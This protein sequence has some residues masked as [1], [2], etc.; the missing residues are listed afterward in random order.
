MA[1]PRQAVLARNTWRR[2]KSQGANRL[3]KAIKNAFLAAIRRIGAFELVARSRWRTS[4]LL[5]LGFHGVSLQDEHEWSPGI[6]LSPDAFVRRMTLLK[7]GGY[8][9]LPLAEALAGLRAGTLP[10]RSVVLTFDD[11]HYDFHDVTYPI[12]ERFD[13]PS[14]VYLT[15]YY[16]ERNLPVFDLIVSYLLWKRR[17]LREI[18]M[19]WGGETI[20]L[21]NRTS[22]SRAASVPYLR[23]WTARR[24]L[25]GAQKDGFAEALAEAV[26]VDYR[27]IRA[28]R[29]LHL[30]NREEVGRLHRQGVDFQLHTHTHRVPLHES[31]FKAQLRR[32]AACIEDVTGTVP[33]HFCYPSGEW[34]ARFFPW[35]AE[36]GVES[37]VTTEL[38][39]ADARSHPYRLPRLLDHGGIEPVEFEA[40]IAGAGQ[41]LAKRRPRAAQAV[42]ARGYP[43]A[44]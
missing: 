37:A 30:L 7:D 16:S 8:S 34:D 12:L 14:T 9:V 40:W 44:L 26:G 42:S 18:R 20:V 39:L 33:R 27:R 2:P 32:N 23:D 17:D 1:R 25:S 3:R 22:A 29:L 21:D 4:R 19:E 36:L 43:V 6:Y 24:E 10:Q 13:F 31:S 11:G 28:R 38:G 5:V 41:F 15:T 35:L